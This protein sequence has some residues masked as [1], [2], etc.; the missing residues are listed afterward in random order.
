V[1]PAPRS[2]WSRPRADAT[3]GVVLVEKPGVAGGVAVTERL[4][5]AVE[6]AL[7]EATPVAV[8]PALAERA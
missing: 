2:A 5:L 3:V 8:A 1:P 7:V 6:A 4:V